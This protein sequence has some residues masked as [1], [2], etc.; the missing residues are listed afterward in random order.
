[1][2]AGLPKTGLFLATGVLAGIITCSQAIQAKESAPVSP[3]F[4]KPYSASYKASI[5]GVPFSGSGNR[6]LVLNEDG[7]WTL[8]FGASAALFKMEES[9][10]FS[11]RNNRVVS[12]EYT[13]ERPGML[14]RKP[15]QAASF[16]WK[17]KQAN[18]QREEH[19]W[20]IQLQDG[21]ID[22]LAYQ[23]QLRLDLASGKREGLSYLIADDDEVY[24]R[25]FIVE[26]EEILDTQAGKLETVRIKIKR[27]TDKR[28]TWIWLAKNWNY[29]VVKFLQKEGNNEYVIEFK[30]ATIDGQPI[31]SKYKSKST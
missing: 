28:E 12:R 16:D 25:D 26:A 8:D 6:S 1:M 17:A 18:W 30:D 3:D 19:K 2:T 13:Y 24:R 22:N 21:A 15:L 10:T 4:L 31:A 20:S 11:V 9:T 7:S 27:N 23:L 29:F 14:G 5:S